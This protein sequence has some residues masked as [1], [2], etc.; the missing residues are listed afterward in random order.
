MAVS[1]LLQLSQVV[2]VLGQLDILVLKLFRQLFN[3][4]F[5]R[6][7]CYFLLLLD[8]SYHVL[9]EVIDSLSERSKVVFDGLRVCTEHI[10]HFGDLLTQG[11]SHCF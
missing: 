1:L 9:L 5:E 7:D 10:E 4:I 3:F 8:Y 2:K 6:I 11:T